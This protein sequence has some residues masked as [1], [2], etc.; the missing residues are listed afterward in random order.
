MNQSAS[1]QGIELGR[2]CKPSH[3]GVSVPRSPSGR[4]TGLPQLDRSYRCDSLRL[5]AAGVVR[6][7]SLRWEAV[8]AQEWASGLTNCN[9]AA[10]S[11]R[12]LA[13]TRGTAA[14]GYH[15]SGAI[16][17][18]VCP[19][20][21]C[22][23]WAVPLGSIPGRSFGYGSKTIPRVPSMSRVRSRVLL[24]RGRENGMRV[25]PGGTLA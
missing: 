10:P 12:P 16:M 9:A 14:A 18:V 5:D 4:V 1:A 7:S 19:R 20:R 25:V 2:E 21:L 3:V 24:H 17:L 23:D 13:R 6:R 11:S 8:Q 22:S 15:R